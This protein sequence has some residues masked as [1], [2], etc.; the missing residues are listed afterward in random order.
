MAYKHTIGTD[1]LQVK[2]AVAEHEDLI[3][4]S[5]QK[6]KLKSQTAVVARE[7]LSAMLI[8][9]ELREHHHDLL[10]SFD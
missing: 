2:R 7:E 6:L 3:K 4:A 8:K 1:A 10:G 9:Y 5:A